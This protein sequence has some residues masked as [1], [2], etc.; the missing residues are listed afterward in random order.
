[1]SLTIGIQEQII[2]SVPAYFLSNNANVTIDVNGNINAETDYLRPD[3]Q[4][5]ITAATHGQT[6]TCNVTIVPWSA[7]NITLELEKF[8]R[9]G[10]GLQYPCK[11]ADGTLYVVASTELRSSTDAFETTTVLGALPVAGIQPILVTPYGWFLR[12]ISTIYKSLDSGQTWILC[13]DNLLSCLQHGW[14]FYHDTV[15]NKVYVYT[16]EYSASVGVTDKRHK[17]IRGTILPDGSDTWDTVLD[18][19]SVTEY[20]TDPVNNIPSAWHIHVVTVDQSTGDLYVGTGD[21]D[22]QCN[23]L[24]SDDNGATWTTLGTGGQ[25]WRTL[26]I[27]FTDNY[28]YWNMDASTNQSIWRLARTDLVTQSPANDQKTLVATLNNGSMWYHTWAVDDLGNDVL[29]M[30]EAA[31]GQQRD[32]NARVFGIWE[33]L[34]GTNTVEELIVLQSETP[35]EYS[36]MVQLEPRFYDNGFVYFTARDMPYDTS[37][38]KMKFVRTP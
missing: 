35:T 14:D 36:P 24:Y 10:A 30:A 11:A 12:G 31:E 37:I 16:G 27:W 6:E 15:N 28:I 7:N 3:G 8:V 33:N 5:I 2:S 17:I 22:P 1:M 23:I 21:L 32:W 18:L 19:Y 9:A 13:I 29:I 25:E 38:W 4:A 34:D 20:N 26:S